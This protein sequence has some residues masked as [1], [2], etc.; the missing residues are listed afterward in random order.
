MVN[1]VIKGIKGARGMW[2]HIVVQLFVILL[3]FI[4]G[5]AIR[6]KR[7]YMLISGFNNRS[8]EEQKILIENGYPQ[9][10]GNL[11]IMTAI[12]MLILSPLVFTSFP[13]IIEVQYGFMTV[14]LLGGFIYVAKYEIPVK[15]KKSYW[16]ASIFTISVIG[17]ISVLFYLGYQSNELVVKE[18]TFEITGIYGDEWKVEDIEKIEL[19]N[20]MPNVTYKENGFG[21]SN[22]SKGYF[23]VETY[24]SSLLFIRNGG[25]YLLIKMKN[26]T[27]I[28]NGENSEQTQSW[29]EQINDKLE[30]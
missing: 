9:K 29:Y 15:R 24:G 23:H 8:E 10:T 30:T 13:Y 20:E 2:V 4:L 12:G 21:M 6:Y 3:F 1:L 26:R 16:F 19:L 18:Q 27:I 5:W 14:F 25:P 7:Q 17:F 22:L 28:I 11:L